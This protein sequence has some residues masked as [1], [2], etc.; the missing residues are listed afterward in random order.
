MYIMIDH[1]FKYINICFDN[2]LQD[3]PVALVAEYMFRELKVPGLNP[4]LV[5]FIFL[6]FL[7][8]AVFVPRNNQ[9]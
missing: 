4:T 8:F 1:Q 7:V 9:Y 2:H 3:A 6:Y 5:K